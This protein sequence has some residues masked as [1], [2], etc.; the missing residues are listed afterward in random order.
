MSLARRIE[1]E[2]YI[3]SKNITKDISPY[4]TAISISD[5][6]DGQT[7]TADIEL[8]D[9]DRLWVND[10][11]PSRGDTVKICFTRNNWRGDGAV[12][13]F[14]FDL[15]EIDEIENSYPPNVCKIRLNSVES[16][17]ELKSSDKSR[18]WEKVTLKKICADI[19]A[20]AGL[21]LVFDSQKNPDINRA[22]Q[23]NESNL[24]FLHKLAKKHGLILRVSEKQL[25]L[26]DEEKLEASE[27]VKTFTYRGEKIISFSGR[28]TLSEIYSSAEVE[29]TH[30]KKK[31]K[32]SGRF[33]D[34]SKGGGKTLRI[35]KKVSSQAEA[36][37]LARKELRDKNKKEVEVKLEV[38]GE[39]E[40]LAGNVVALDESFG[41]Y[42]GNYIIDRADWKVGSGFTCNLDLRK[43][44]SGY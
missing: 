29:Y 42:K 12:E 39:F 17:S 3:N 11:F 10:W 33:E 5:V 15:F 36:D 26:S 24:A 31:E 27:S 35:K 6:L 25:I 20:D 21:T 44:L 41:F 23:K 32:I 40:Y 1:S 2:I 18:S 22:E 4:L 34:K 37:E 8:E 14:S 13:T 7:C 30:G 43:C 16:A 9:S 38:L 19:A 28:A